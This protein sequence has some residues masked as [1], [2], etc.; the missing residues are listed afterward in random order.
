MKASKD[1]W[2]ETVEQEELER[3]VRAVLR[4]KKALEETEHMQDARRWVGEIPRNLL[5]IQGKEI[6][7]HLRV[8]R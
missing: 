4:D 2:S 1:H 5:R 3:L 6:T 8:R 7:E